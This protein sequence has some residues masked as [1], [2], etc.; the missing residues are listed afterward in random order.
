MWLLQRLDRAH[1]EMSAH[2]PNILHDGGGR[3]LTLRTRM[4]QYWRRWLVWNY[5]RARR[6]TPLIGG[7]Y[8]VS[9]RPKSEMPVGSVNGPK[10]G[11]VTHHG[12]GTRR[13]WWQ[14]F[15]CL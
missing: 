13:R 4:R 10:M 8:L 6:P 2:Q 7:W 12:P 14:F 5:T 9:Y 1:P 3:R 11:D 15:R